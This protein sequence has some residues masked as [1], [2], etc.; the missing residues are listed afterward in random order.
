[1]SR[2]ALTETSVRI[3]QLV[4]ELGEA[5]PRQIAE[6]LC[7]PR[8]RI[9]SSLTNFRKAGYLVSDGGRQRPPFATVGAKKFQITDKGRQAAL[10]LAMPNTPRP[11]APGTGWSVPPTETQTRVL[12][13]IAARIRKGRLP[14]LREVAKAFGSSL[15]NIEDHMMRLERKGMVSWEGGKARTIQLTAAGVAHLEKNSRY[16]FLAL[17]SCPTCGTNRVGPG[18]C[19]E[20]SRLVRLS[21]A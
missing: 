2:G 10:G 17:Q 3:L 1:M 14:S 18:P 19:P 4:A 11:R 15:H 7:L 20:C 9:S 13:I 6:R 8:G 5:T 21:R 12:R 16:G